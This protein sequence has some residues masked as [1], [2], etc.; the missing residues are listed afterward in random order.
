MIFVMQMV[1]GQ[2]NN[3]MNEQIKKIKET[4]GDKKSTF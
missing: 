1:I 4:V 2:C 3:F